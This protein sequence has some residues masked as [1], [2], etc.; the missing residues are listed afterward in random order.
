MAERGGPA[1]QAGIRYQDQVAA[2]YLGRMLDPRERPRRDQPVEVRI[3]APQSVDDFVVRFADGARRF[4]QVKLTLEA[5]G[6]AWQGLWP[7]FL[8]QLNTDFKLE[9]RL[10]LVLGEPSALASQ[11]IEI[12][13]RH[14]SSDII[15]WQRRLTAEQLKLV[16]SIQ[17]LLN[18]DIQNVWQ[19][20]NH[21]D[22]S[23]FP[24]EMLVR[25]YVPHWMPSAS[26]AVSALF[27]VLTEMA[28]EGAAKRLSFDGTALYD[29][30]RAEAGIIIRDPQ[31]WGSAQY[32]DAIITLSTISVPGTD[33]VQS[34]D[35]EYLWPKCNRYDRERRPDFDDDIPGWRNFNIDTPIDLRNF[36]NAELNA[37]VVIAGPGFGKT[38]LVN[39]IARKTA[40]EGLLPAIIPVTKLSESD[41]TIPAYLTERHNRDFDVKIDWRTSA[42]S[43]SFILLLDGLDEVSSDRRTLILERLKV[44]RATYPGLRWLVTVR[45]AAAIVP[46]EDATVVELSP[47]QDEDVRLYVDFYRPGEPLV[48]QTLLNKMDVHPELARLVR[49]PIF[50]ALMLVMRQ[51]NESLKR[52]DL[53]DI[54]LE[55][56]FR[57]V[58]YKLTQNDSVDASLLRQ[59]AECAAFEA[60]EKNTVGIKINQLAQCIKSFGLSLNTDDVYEAMI[61]RGILRKVNSAGCAFPFPIVHEYLA[62]TELLEKHSEQIPTRLGM[63]AKRPWAQ[64]IQFALERHSNPGAII[65]Q[66]LEREDDVFHTGL[67]LLGRCLANGMSVSPT[68]RNIMGERFASLWGT[69]PFHSEKMISSIIVD[70]FSQ[71]LHPA[72]RQRLGERYLLHCGADVIVARLRDNDISLNV[73]DTLLAG[74]TEFLSNLGD[75]QLEV[76]RL[77]N[78]VLNRYISHF[79]Q[80]AERTKD[81]ETISI[82]IGHM[83]P[84]C[85]DAD[86]AI[87]ISND[88]SLPPEIR[89]AT[90]YL[91]QQKLT[92]E[93]EMLVVQA[94]AVDDYSSNAS[95]G[96]VLSSPYVDT[97]TLVRLIQS[98]QVPRKNAMDIMSGL[99]GDWQREGATS[100]FEELITLDGLDKDIRLIAS[101]YAVNAGLLDVFDV[102]LD[103]LPVMNSDMVMRTIDLLGHIPE[104][105]I[106]EQAVSALA[107]RK[108]NAKERVS[109]IG[110]LATGLRYRKKMCGL[111]SGILESIPLHPGRTVPYSLIEEWIAQDDYEPY[112]SLRL[113][114]NAV[115]LGVP[116]TISKLQD[117]FYLAIGPSIEENVAHDY[118]A[119]RALEALHA[120][121]QGPSV[122]KLEELALATT[123]NFA[124]SIVGVI[125]KGGK[126]SDVEILLRLYES[127]SSGMLR[128]LILSV[129]EPLTGRLGLRITQSGKKLIATAI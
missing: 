23:V 7:S 40:L 83:R 85:V 22:I 84:G 43:G 17:L 1:T 125:A 55:T 24:S 47:L 33:F 42:D 67:R 15:E 111:D 31:H 122:D 87:K 90:W 102:L 34:T 35:A 118:L 9:D 60:L 45:D 75:L 92:H 49:I 46:T 126:A 121:G 36:P 56:L 106:V 37:V 76:N 48:A 68:Q 98:P 13:R 95:A 20:I 28:L 103:Q 89:L 79:R 91:T 64:A 52:S 25:D 127:V 30:L 19:I 44:F 14:E 81:R 93:I 16:S 57:P 51:E 96:K 116:N 2:L 117:A 4:Y 99:F 82:L 120:N 18:D 115:E 107:S 61:R 104:R 108:W 66:I 58:A 63:I 97:K 8:R 86:I 78:A 21:L 110:S 12:T 39:A 105:A 109:I 62:S 72:V 53:L 50:L 27:S 77:G 129:L 10:E 41:L 80:H 128:I 94:M 114:L 88:T 100:K 112:D 70:A 29:R 59:I 123:Y 101:L 113:L 11:L 5:K 74:D 32:R 3:E 124:S 73:I 54:Y 69:G 65:D 119:G 26:V 6:S 38:T 71:P